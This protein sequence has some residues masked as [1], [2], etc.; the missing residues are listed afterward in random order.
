MIFLDTDIISYH[1][2]A[3]TKIK[4]KI[5]ETIGNGEKIG[6]TVINIYEIL[7]GFKW[8]NNKNKEFQF[9][10]FLKNTVIF[11][12]DNDVIN[13]A[14]SIYAKLRTSGKTIGDADILIAAIVIRN[15]GTLVSNNIKHYENIEGLVLVNWS[16]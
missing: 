13:I 8:R 7:R 10:K 4:K 9:N 16:I 1:I 2:T 12:I 11:T 5:F 6:M 15:K 3:N 14:S